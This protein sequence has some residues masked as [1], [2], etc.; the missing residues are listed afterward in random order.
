MDFIEVD[1][2]GEETL[3]SMSQG[4]RLNKWMFNQMKPYIG[5]KTLE[6]GSGIGNISKIFI[7]GSKN[8]DLSDIRDQYVNHLKSEYPNNKVFKINLVNPE[9]DKEYSKILSS[10]DLV[11]A[12]NVIEHIEDDKQAITNIFK[13]LKPNGYAYILVPA[14]QILYNN[15]DRALLHFRRYNKDSLKNIFQTNGRFQKSWYFN[16]AGIFGWF[17]VGNVLKRN[18]IPESNMKVYNFF[19]PLFRLID[20][21]TFRKIGL[22]V[23]AVYKKI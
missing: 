7:Q 14:H 8:I 12:L 5:D 21:I 13:L 4:V 19:T 2:I 20:W 1:T 3:K 16:F 17:I 15:F 18:I 11:F 9:F 23:I 10:Y 6:I 22:S